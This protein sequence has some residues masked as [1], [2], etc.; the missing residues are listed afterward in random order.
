MA[1]PSARIHPSKRHNNPMLHKNGQPRLR[2]LNIGQLNAL[3]EKTQIKKI[4]AKIMRELQRR[5]L[6]SLKKQGF[7]A[8]RYNLMKSI[9][10]N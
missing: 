5:I 8:K 4:K 1:T 7:K 9:S 3:L 2:P 10:D 6:V